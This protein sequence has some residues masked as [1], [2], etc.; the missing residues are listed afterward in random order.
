MDSEV[1]PEPNAI[2]KIS[3]EIG[4][5][6]W[7]VGLKFSE[8]RPPYFLLVPLDYPEILFGGY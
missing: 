7:F 5:T 1:F 2:P 6:N 8:H 4:P 3:N